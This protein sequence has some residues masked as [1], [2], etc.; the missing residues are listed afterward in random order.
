M[1][2][3]LITCKAAKT[4]S[5]H[6]GPSATVDLFRVYQDYG[7]DYSD[8]GEGEEAES[9]DVENMYYTAKC[10]P[11]FPHRRRILI[12]MYSKEGR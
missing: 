1:M 2:M 4:R 10:T 6:R 9:A 5:V 11:I 12:P 3:M 7:F 8:D